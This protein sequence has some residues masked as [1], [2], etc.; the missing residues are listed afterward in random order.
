M[1]KKVII[2]KQ[3]FLINKFSTKLKVKKNN[4]SIEVFVVLYNKSYY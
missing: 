2:D 1:D 3:L 4:E